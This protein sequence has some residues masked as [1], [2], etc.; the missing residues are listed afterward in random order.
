MKEEE[1]LK[2]EIKIYKEFYR[3]L[4]YKIKLP[5]FKCKICGQ[6]ILLTPTNMRLYA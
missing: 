2:K 5:S 3:K 6:E 1:K 4:D